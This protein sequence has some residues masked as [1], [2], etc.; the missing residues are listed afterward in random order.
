MRPLLH[1]L[2]SAVMT[3]LVMA[4]AVPLV[5]LLVLVV[6]PL[7]HLWQPSDRL[8]LVEHLLQTEAGPYLETRVQARWP[9]TRTAGLSSLEGDAAAPRCMDCRATR[10]GRSPRVGSVGLRSDATW[11]AQPL[12]RA[13]DPPSHLDVRRL[14]R[15]LRENVAQARRA[16]DATMPGYPVAEPRCGASRPRFV[17]MVGTSGVLARF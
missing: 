8:A 9:S 7:L 10:G 17:A 5:L 11:P 12:A 14:C 6:P 13:D 1:R 3:W 15:L 2:S 4:L 16:I